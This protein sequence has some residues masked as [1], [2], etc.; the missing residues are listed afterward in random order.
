MKKHFV[1]SSYILN[2]DSV[3]LIFHP[4]LKKWLPPGGHIEPNESPVEAVKREVKEEV[5]LD[6]EIITDENLFINRWNAKSFARPFLCLEE[7]IPA[8]KNEEA[9][10]HFDFIYLA[11][12]L[13][14]Q[15]AA[16][17]P[18]HPM[19]WFALEEISSLDKEKEMFWETFDVLQ[20]IFNQKIKVS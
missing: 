7:E 13:N 2:K 20:L 5:G 6:I 1:S 9:H 4:K 10:K 8:T 15:S 18:D 3:L 17:S 12:A 14:P 19:K 16:S 11:K